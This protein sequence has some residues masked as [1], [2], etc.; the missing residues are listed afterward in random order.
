MPEVKVAF[1]A[2]EEFSATRITDHIW[3]LLRFRALF[4][5]VES[6]GHHGPN[7]PSP[8]PGNEASST[9]AVSQ[10][11]VQAFLMNA[12][13][14]Y[15]FYLCLLQKWV[16][17]G[18]VEGDGWANSWPLPP[19]DV[20]LMFYIHMLSPKRFQKDMAAEYPTI[21]GSRLSFPLARLRQHPLNHEPSQRKWEAMFPN[22]P[23]QLFEFEPD[24]E[25]PHLSTSIKRPLDVRG[26]KCGS[27]VCNAK[28]STDK[29]QIIP[30]AEWSA[31]RLAKRRPPT[32][33]SCGIAF[34][35]Q[36]AG[37]NSDFANFCEAVFGQ[38]VF[39]LWDAPLRQ[40]AFVDR[41]LAETTTRTT[42]TAAGSTPKATIT[43]SPTQVL[44]YQ[45]RYFKFLGL[46]KAHQSTTFVP[47]LDIDLVWHTHQ[48][49]PTAYDDYC[50]THIGH[51]VNHDDT[52]PSTG[53]STALDDTKRLWALA[54]RELY[55]DP[56]P[57]GEGESAAATN[58]TNEERRNSEW[59]E[60]RIASVRALLPERVAEVEAAV[61]ERE[62][63]LAEFDRAGTVEAR[64]TEAEQARQR[65]RTENTRL[66][67]V[68]RQY[69]MLR[70]SSARAK[71]AMGGV[72]PRLRLWRWRW[73]DPLGKGI[74]SVVPSE[75]Q[76]KPSPLAGNWD[77]ESRT[78]R[79]RPVRTW[80][81]TYRSSWRPD[82][83]GGGSF[84]GLAF[85]ADY[86]SGSYVG[87]SGDGWGVSS[88]GYSGGCG[89]GGSSGGGC[90]GG[91]SSGGGCG[92]GCGGGGGG[93]C[94]GGC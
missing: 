1:P 39:G 25:T 86:Y 38:H 5:H 85:G 26:Y 46:I 13:V 8:P 81:T 31:Y 35:S 73:G 42:G 79:Y 77:S 75:A 27:D 92:G 62:R 7:Y 84:G 61:A 78:E 69:S 2:A 70:D 47:T 16:A 45:A 29:Y 93:G 4:D 41:I 71:S 9:E 48:L 58:E 33:P 90:G 12:E 55:L 76:I 19:W 23:Y 17:E 6:P 22:I 51:P 15:S 36:R 28:T 52:I 60:R 40:I 54:Y 89:G 21:W 44:A 82:R 18:R 56:G 72:R 24:R 87:C 30:M 14:R 88:G 3:I 49:A 43:L 53:R 94:G 74:L 59:R 80:G 32:C 11:R 63:R 10:W 34:S 91:G 37:Y 64:R 65:I 50:R 67:E 66:D 83:N 57:A 68:R 20:A